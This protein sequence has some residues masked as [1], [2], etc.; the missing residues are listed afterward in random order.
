MT[1]R[2]RRA[3][4]VAATVAAALAS[5]AIFAGPA[6]AATGITAFEGGPSTTQA[7]G[8]PNVTWRINYLTRVNEPYD[9]CNCDD[10]RTIAFHFPTGFIGDPHSLPRCTLAEFNVGNCA[11]ESQV[12]MIII[13]EGSGSTGIRVP[14]YNM[15]THPDQAGQLGFIFPLLAFPIFIDLRGRT[16]GDYG[17]DSVTFPIV[18]TLV[19]PEIG[20]QLWGVPA[21]PENDFYRFVTPL[22]GFGECGFLQVCGDGHVSGIPSNEAPAPYLQNPTTCDVPL[23]F[24]ADIKYYSGQTYH[25]ET[26][27]PATTGCNQLSFN[28]SLSAT[29][30]TDGADSARGSTSTSRS[31]RRR[32]PTTPSPSEIKAARV[33]LPEGFSINPN[34]ANGKTTCAGADTAIGTLG[35]RHLPRVLEDRHAVARHRGAAGRR[36]PGLSTSAN[37][38]PANATGCCSP[39]T[40]SPPTSSSPARSTPTRRPGSSWSPSKTCRRARCR[41][42]TC[43]SSAPSAACS[44]RRPSAAPTR[45]KA[46]SSP[47]TTSF[48][49]RA[50]TSYFAIDTG[51]NGKPCPGPTRPFD[52]T[53]RPAAPTTTAGAHSSVHAATRPRRRRAEPQRPDRQD[54]ARILG[55]A[56]GRPLLSGGGDRRSSNSP[57]YTGLAEL[58]APACPA[59]SQVG[60]AMAGAGAGSR[61]VYVARQGLP[62][63]SL[64]GGPAEPGGRR[65]RRS[66]APTTS[67]TSP[68]ARRSTSTAAPLRS[69]TVSDPFPQILEGVPLRTRSV[70]IDLDRPEL[71]A[72]PDQLRPVLG[73]RRRRRQTKA[74][75]ATSIGPLPGRQLRRTRLSARSWR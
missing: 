24:S 13:G 34:A 61:P 25:A 63:R 12:G 36:S 66:R 3:T 20:V 27:W 54:P 42:S 65:S 37:R 60:T 15:E 26:P 68:S 74:A 31:R 56:E 43:T 46:N 39:R 2:S 72:Q 50:S 30:T 40:V 18:H 59:A 45:W 41:A 11:A 47:G 75:L 5:L 17:L 29:P 49:C 35:R 67:A 21:A 55:H 19:F 28:P 33:T 38:S 71:R 57:G 58:A 9:A 48:R 62:R 7:G 23:T 32:A 22:V 44:R 4:L 8:H 16:D 52:P 70:Q 6:S 14:L 53:M 10:P 73:R 69:P 64:Q 51:P 1:T